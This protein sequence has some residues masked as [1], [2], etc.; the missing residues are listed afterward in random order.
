[1]ETKVDDNHYTTKGKKFARVTRILEVVGLTDFSKIPERSREYY[2]ARG[3]M[4]HLMFQKVEEGTADNY[5]WDP[6][7]EVYRAGHAAF[8][9]DTG[10]KAIPGGIEMR[11]S[12]P[13][14]FFGLPQGGE[15]EGVC[16]TL[17]RLGRMQ[18]NLTLLDYKTTTVH[19]C[20]AIQTALYALMLPDHN[21]GE[22]RRFGVAIL[23]NGRYKMTPEYQYSDKAAAIE[24]LRKYRQ[25]V[26]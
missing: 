5:D 22:V 1:M 12:A 26:K 19:P 20:C 7:C 10:F 11:V 4:N 9:R 3:S 8:L 25:E 2:M 6:R 15:E 16:G 21:F 23:K 18:G 24:A 14:S 17:D 13:W